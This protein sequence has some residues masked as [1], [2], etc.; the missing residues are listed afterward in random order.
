MASARCGKQSPFIPL[1]SCTAHSTAPPISHPRCCPPAWRPLHRRRAVHCGAAGAAA[2]LQ[3]QRAA[4]GAGAGPHLLPPRLCAG[5]RQ[6]GRGAGGA[7]GRRGGQRAQHGAGGQAGQGRGG[8]GCWS[9]LGDASGACEQLPPKGH[10]TP[11]GILL[12]RPST[13]IT[14]GNLWFVLHPQHPTTPPPTP[15]HPHARAGPRLDHAGQAVPD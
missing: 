11:R 12:W 4:G 15:T 6:P 14:L 2:F 5:H 8:A 3:A 10:F 13:L 9:E 7:G 1:L